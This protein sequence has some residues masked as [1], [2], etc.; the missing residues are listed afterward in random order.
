MI[1]FSGFKKNLAIRMQ[2][3]NKMV[4]YYQVPDTCSLSLKGPDKDLS[5]FSIGR[6][7]IGTFS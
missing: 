1:L 3:Q 4:Y 7:I 6:T 2:D 5:I